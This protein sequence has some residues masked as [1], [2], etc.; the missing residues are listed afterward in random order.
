MVSDR[1]TPRR[2]PTTWYHFFF[3]FWL[4][5]AACGILI[6]QPGVE[7]GPSAVRARSP[8]HWIARESQ[9]GT[10]FIKHKIKQHI[11]GPFTQWYA[12]AGLN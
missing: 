10:I 5:H 4:H 3:F 2:L 12:R 8:N 11:V 1:A 7:P 9:H 6:P